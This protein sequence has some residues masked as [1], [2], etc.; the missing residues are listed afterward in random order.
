MNDYTPTRS[1]LIALG[2]ER[3]TMR[4][5]S[6]FLDEKCLLLAGEML[7][8]VRRHR[9]VS[10][11]LREL[12]AAASAALR[13]AIGRH[14]VN[15]LQVHAAATLSQSVT[16]TGCHPTIGGHPT[17]TTDTYASFKVQ[18]DC[19]GCH[20]YPPVGTDTVQT[21]YVKI[22]DH[23]KRR[24]GAAASSSTDAEFLTAHEGCT[25]CHG[26]SGNGTLD[27]FANARTA[28]GGMD[29]YTG[30]RTG[31]VNLNGISGTDNNQNTAYNSS[32]GGCAKACHAADWKLT[33]TYPSGH[34]LDRMR[35]MTAEQLLKVIDFFGMMTQPAGAYL[36]LTTHHS[37]HHRAQL[38]VYLRMLDIAIPGMYGP[39]ADER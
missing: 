21:G 24:R 14:A 4:E 12:D 2:D 1:L 18:M 34:A 29:A 38:G 19:A 20:S 6:A 11:E 9:A 26:V 13:A 35:G 28:T 37:V 5:G 36:A 3:R 16:C 32:T 33:G 8:E 27:G 15:G 31:S 22:V 39:S 7:R 30:H 10:R 25:L 17:G 23:T